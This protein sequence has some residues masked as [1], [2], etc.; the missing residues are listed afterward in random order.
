MFLNF[1]N[2]EFLNINKDLR[3]AMETS[4]RKGSN[5]GKQRR[6]KT[7]ISRTLQVHKVLTSG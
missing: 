1:G 4:L 5:L 2:V 7:S 3:S 6:F